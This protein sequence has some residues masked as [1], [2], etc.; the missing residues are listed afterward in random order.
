MSQLVKNFTVE[1]LNRFT[2]LLLRNFTVTQTLLLHNFTDTQNCYLHH[3]NNPNH[4]KESGNL[5]TDTY[6]VSF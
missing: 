2:T 6:H 5:K 3:K 1:Q 4:Q